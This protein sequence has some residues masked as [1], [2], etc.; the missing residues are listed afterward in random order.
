MEVVDLFQFVVY[1]GTFDITK[2][3]IHIPSEQFGISLY[4][5]V[6]L[7]E[8]AIGLVRG[9]WAAHGQTVDLFVVAVV[10]RHDNTTRCYFAI[11]FHIYIY[12]YI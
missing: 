7:T 9:W 4:D 2:Y 5:V 12:I 11:Y 8:P 3:I 1:F 6:I 10:C